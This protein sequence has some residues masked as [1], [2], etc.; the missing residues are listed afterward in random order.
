MIWCVPVVSAEV[1]EY[2]IYNDSEAI[3]EEEKANEN[4]ILSEVRTTIDVRFLHIV[5]YECHLKQWHN[6]LWI[7]HNVLWRRA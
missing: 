1:F 4:G 6:T 2:H 3:T 7:L 5:L